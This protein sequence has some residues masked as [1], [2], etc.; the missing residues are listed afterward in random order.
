M[1]AASLIAMK[2]GLLAEKENRRIAES[3]D[4]LGRLPRISDLNP[5]E[6][7]AAVSHDKKVTGGRPTFVLPER[8][9]SVVLRSDVPPQYVVSS[10][11]ESSP[12]SWCSG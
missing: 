10:I 11:R 4:S 5:S 2:V 1:K 12:D 7:A 3:V 9:G 8:T 6:V